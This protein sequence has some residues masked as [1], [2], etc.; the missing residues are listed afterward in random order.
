MTEPVATEVGR[1]FIRDIIQADLDQGKYREIVTRFPPEPN[2]YLHI[3]HAKSIALN[4]GIAQEF[5]GRCHLRFD[6]TNPV[7]EEQ[8]YID[9]IQADVHWLGFDW[10]K[11]L[12]FA[13]DYF[14]RLYEWA[15]KLIRDGLA[16]V[17]D[18]TQEEIRLARGT[19]TEPGKDSP[20]RDR[21]VDENLDLFR[22]MKAGEFPNGARVLRAK[23]D[24]SSG[25][26][27][28]RDPVLYRILHAHHPRTGTKWSIYPSYDYAHGQSDAIEGITHSICTL[29]FEDHR[30]LY[31]WFIE[32]LPVPSKPHQYEMARL[33]LTYTLLSKRVLTQLVRDGHV[34]G[35]DDPRMPTVAGMRRRGVPPAALREFVKRIGVAK[36]NSVVDVGM[37]EFCIREELNRTSQRRM[38]VLR[39]LK[40][41]IENYPEGQ[42]EEL[43]AINHPDD[44]SAG[45]RK[46]TF[47]RELY[48]EQDDFM[49]NPP[50]KFFRLS[51][52]NEVRLRYAYFVKCTGVIKNDAGEVV[53]LRCTYDPATKGGNA[54]D[55]RK[56]KAT[57]HWLPAATSV[58]A[59]I[60][61]YNQL[62]SNPSPDASNFAADLNPQSLEILSDARIEASVAESN[63]TE[64]MQFERQGYFVRDKDST[65][66][67]PVFSR[68]IGLRDTF[69]KEVAKG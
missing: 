20:F 21:S 52:G 16:Y 42:T 34:A 5:P 25:N 31:D 8:E 6:D 69:A 28:L 65:P 17:D 44:P 60:R 40:V 38:G 62:F 58:P 32:K 24:M 27:N 15:E 43:E 50:K 61:I 13:S 53:E 63:S 2:G 19:L 46:I 11:N 12:F 29:E 23:I 14:D 45:T 56:V 55:G 35:W 36:A 10:G 64:P 1:D 18:Q 9:S 3:G 67:K 48:I 68:T 49:E 57:M 37:L 26:I 30:P 51:P 22:R 47:G 41:V 66:G 59:E 39:P 33:N 54:P 7:K 4:F